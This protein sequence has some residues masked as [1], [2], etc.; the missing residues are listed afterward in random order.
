MDQ[1]LLPEHL[2]PL[3]NTDPSDP[4]QSEMHSDNSQNM[5]SREIP[6]TSLPY[7]QAFHLH[8]LSLFLRKSRI[9]TSSS[10]EINLLQ[11]NKVTHRNQGQPLSLASRQDH[12]EP[13]HPLHLSVHTTSEPSLWTRS[14]NTKAFSDFWCASHS[15]WDHTALQSGVIRG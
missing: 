5:P 14:R 9:I 12:Q 4:L 10:K 7:G 13:R 6:I 8:R 11:G 3:F 2:F 1:H 15:P